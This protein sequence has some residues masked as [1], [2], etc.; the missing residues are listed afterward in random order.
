MRA[1]LAVSLKLASKEDSGRGLN[2]EMPADQD[3]QAIHRAVH[4]EVC[5]KLGR[6]Q[7]VSH[8]GPSSLK[9]TPSMRTCLYPVQM[10]KPENL[11]GGWSWTR[12][13][14]PGGS[15][16]LGV[17]PPLQ[18]PQLALQT[19]ENAWKLCPLRLNPSHP[20]QAEEPLLWE[21]RRPGGPPVTSPGY[22]QGAVS[23]HTVSAWNYQPA[24]PGLWAPGCQDAGQE[25]HEVLQVSGW[26]GTGTAVL[27]LKPGSQPG[28]PKGH[29][30]A[31]NDEHLLQRLEPNRIIRQLGKK[32]SGPGILA[33]QC[34]GWV[35]SEQIWA[36][37]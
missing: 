12:W 36:T 15:G 27:G 21:A 29:L 6:A 28:S 25:A 34:G 1:A 35:Y 32:I 22:R 37:M 26:T 18:S 8:Q 23:V 9:G 2:R 3:K 17:C 4:A 19:T 16:G 33:T 7:K 20:H 10:S 14:G 5:D 11:P 30:K 13:A 24:A 31:S